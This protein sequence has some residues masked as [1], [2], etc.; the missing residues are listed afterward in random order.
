MRWLDDM[1]VAYKLFLLGMIAVVGLLG[2]SIA[3]YMG[4]RSAQEDINT[5]YE[6]SVQ[7]HDY[8]GTAMTGARYAQG[9]AVVMTTCRNDNAR[10]Q[11]LK[12]KYETGVK[13]VEDS[14]AGYDAIPIKDPETDAL[15]ET[16]KGNWKDF[17]ATLDKSVQQSLAGQYDEAL[18]TY[19]ATGTKQ[20]GVL[21]TNFAKLGQ[22]EHQKAIDL[23]AKTDA[24]T[25]ATIRNIIIMVVIILVILL[26]ACITIAK[27]IMEPLTAI[28]SACRKMR[29]GD[30]RET[31]YQT[32]RGDEFGEMLHD[33]ADMCRTVSGLMKTT[34]ETAQ[35]L[36]AASEELTASAH[37]SAQASEQV[38]N[39]VTSAAQASAEQQ[40]YIED[41]EE[42][43]GKTVTSVDRLHATADAVEG[44]AKT[45][46]S[47]AVEGG[48]SVMDAV[49]DIESVE[50]I[51]KSSAQTV[52]Q[53][54][55]SSQQI[56]SIVETISGIAEQTNLLALN[57]AIEAARAGEH[58]RGFAVVA[59]EVRKLA[60]ASQTAAQQ[61]TDLITGIQKDTDA[62]V[63]SMQSG[64]EAVQSGTAAVAQLKDAFAE[65]ETAVQNVAKSANDMVA[66][67]QQVGTQTGV[68][69]EKTQQIAG[70]GGK[71][72]NEMESVSAASEQQSA[73]AGE[74]A[75]ASESLA[76]LAQKLSESLQKF[77]Y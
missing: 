7:S 28:V 55:K 43:V 74:I 5:M 42:S 6:S 66:E 14:I 27:K 9:M 18:A 52:D 17:H 24:D 70:N 33:F 46:H 51:V 47:R 19:S 44:D 11:D 65:I 61:I 67:L 13:M 53:L 16:I 49:H 22:M 57:A 21:G 54:G 4:L 10:L 37:Q 29:D 38:A 63:A 45:A 40:Q 23:K 69:Q 50:A 76:Q 58:G 72:V 15:M 68:V 75:T 60:E 31:G 64:S 71:V 34:N 35:H 1:K 62:A 73:S 26:A 8:V 56:G 12:G 32:E 41:S 2:T 3:G 48:R 20:G 30:F 77:Q 59:D 36:A 25:S 39:S